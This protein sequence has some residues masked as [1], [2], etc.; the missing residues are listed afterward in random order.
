MTSRQP[1]DFNKGDALD[2]LLGGG[3]PI[4][5]R[6]LPSAP[7]FERIRAE[8]PEF[9]EKC[10][11]CKGTGSFRS[12]S[13]RT[14]GQCFHCKGKG[15]FAFKTSPEKRAVSRESAA[16]RKERDQAEVWTIFAKENEGAA[17]WILANA[18]TFAFAAS[19]RDAVHKF[20]HLTE[21]QMDAVNRCISRHADRIAARQVAQTEQVARSVDLTASKISEA[22]AAARGKGLKRLT[23]RYEGIKIKQSR[24]DADT[25]F[26]TDHRAWPDQTYYGKIVASRFMPTRECP[27]EIRT[28]LAIIAQDPAAAAKVYGKETGTC[29]CCGAELTD[30]VSIANGIGP[31]CAGNYG[32]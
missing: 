19:M 3:A 21:G 22:F 23:L 18:P 15:S 9:T 17:A 11:K 32:F 20:G 29:C 10:P 27:D 8:V 14:V 1:I 5:P 4:T 24:K 30:P 13:G 6:T 2:D 12:W 31:I 25:L 26:V 16:A 28:R 7:E